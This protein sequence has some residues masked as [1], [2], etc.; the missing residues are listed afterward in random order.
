[1]KP[2]D[3]QIPWSLARAV[4]GLRQL[5]IYR[6][7][8]QGNSISKSVPHVSV[9]RFTLSLLI[10]NTRLIG[11]DPHQLKKPKIIRLINFS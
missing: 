2:L 5:H 4:H 10:L 7:S 11:K 8:N 1:M 9:A 3:S 6:Y